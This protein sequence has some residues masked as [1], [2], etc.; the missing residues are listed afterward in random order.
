[1]KIIVKKKI[2]CD[3]D[4]VLISLVPSWLDIFNFYTQNDI[5]PEDIKSWNIES[6]IP[7]EHR[8]YFW[9]ILSSEEL[10][11]T[12]QPQSDSQIYIKKII[13]NYDL[14]FI[15]ATHW[16]NATMKGNMLNRLFPFV[17]TYKKLII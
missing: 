9:G 16:T 14:Y 7:E 11:E 10:W 5:Q 17:D 2:G 1:M 13:E 4:D 15:T 6:Y 3:V 12:I 8:K